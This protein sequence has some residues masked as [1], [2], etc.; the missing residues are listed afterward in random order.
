VLSKAKHHLESSSYHSHLSEVEVAVLLQRAVSDVTFD[1]KVPDVAHVYG[2]ISRYSDLV[3]SCV[4]HIEGFSEVVAVVVAVVA[5]VAVMVTAEVSL[6]T[7]SRSGSISGGSNGSS[8][9]S[10]G[11]SSSVR[12]V[13]AVVAA[14]A[15]AVVATLWIHVSAT[16]SLRPATL[17]LRQG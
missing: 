13:Q 11:T 6:F 14:V 3:A 2:Y 8:E 12:A 4:C 9:S 5:A 16:L 17:S 10:S 1:S 15:A 7:C